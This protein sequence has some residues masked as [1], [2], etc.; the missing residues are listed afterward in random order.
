VVSIAPTV[1]ISDFIGQLKGASSHEVNQKLQGK[2]LEWLTGYG[3]VSFGTRDLE[4]VKH[5]VRD[6]R[7]RH[8]QGRVEQRLERIVSVEESA[9]AERR[10]AP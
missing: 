5:Y 1:P 2:V 3:V 4:W 9:E 8:A 10:E 6:Q 7:Q